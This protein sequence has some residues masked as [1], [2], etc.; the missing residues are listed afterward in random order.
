MIEARV[1]HKLQPW[2]NKL[3]YNIP[4]HITPNMLT[5]TAF[6][7]GI[8]AGCSIAYGFYLIA[9]YFLWFSGLCD[10]MDGTV[11]RLHNNAQ[12]IGAYI[13]LITDRMVEAAIILG[14]AVA[15]PQY[16]FTYLLFLIAVLLH[17]ST[18]LAAG[19]LSLN[20]GEKSMYYDH[21][22]VERAEAFVVFS[23][24]LLFPDYIFLWLMSFNVLVLLDGLRRFFK[25][26]RSA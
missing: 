2:F 19:A 14:F 16:L 9:L 17:F 23:L 6:I 10:V 7:S 3:G 5:M 12:K 15:Y 1:R 13:D 20:T 4:H 22:I 18:F 11:A 26:I 8:V 24:M 21:S 25:V